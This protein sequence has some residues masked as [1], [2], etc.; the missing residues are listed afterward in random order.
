MRALTFSRDC[1][2]V[3]VTRGLSESFRK[4]GGCAGRG[5]VHANE[6]HKAAK[7]NMQI[8]L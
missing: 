6:M 4:Q 7:H 2:N 8:T 5:V 3:S 1:L